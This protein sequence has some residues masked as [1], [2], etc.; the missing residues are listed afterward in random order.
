MRPSTMVDGVCVLRD[1]P[2]VRS[3]FLTGIA[4]TARC[5]KDEDLDQANRPPS[6]I[7]E[8]SPVTQLTREP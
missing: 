8:R 2:L 5:L 1:E 3:S 7:R 4:S 6:G